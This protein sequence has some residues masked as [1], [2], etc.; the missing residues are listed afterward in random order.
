ISCDTGLHHAG[1]RKIRMVKDIKELTFKP[2][3]HMLGQGKPFCQV[4]VTPEEIGTTQG[5]AAEGSGLAMLRAVAAVALPCTRINR[6]YKCV[7]IE[8]LK[9]SRRRYTR[10]RMMLIQRNAGNSTSKLRP[11]ALH[12]SLFL[13]GDWIDRRIGR[14][15]HR[16]RNSAVPKRC[17]G[18]LPAVEQVAQRMILHSDRQLIYILRIEIVPD[19]I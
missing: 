11:A 16:E 2:Q 13:H 14:A 7:R 6:R 4:E 18:N 15:Q 1:K 17:S 10:N 12:N 9:C 3:L 19:V 8:P 5:I